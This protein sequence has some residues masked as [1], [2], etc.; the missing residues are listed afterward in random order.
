MSTDDTNTEEPR[1]G[2]PEDDL[3]RKYREALERKSSRSGGN[4]PGDGEGE[5]KIHDAH[6]PAG[7]KR[8][9]RRRSGS[10]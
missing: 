1:P 9:F 6:G 7:G 4:Q 5:S 10:S 8:A 2:A 3:K